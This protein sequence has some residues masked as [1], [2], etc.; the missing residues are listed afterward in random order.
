M[1][2]EQNNS[3]HGKN[4]LQYTESGKF[5]Y[6]AAFPH[7]EGSREAL[8]RVASQ[9]AGCGHWSAVEARKFEQKCTTLKFCIF[10]KPEPKIPSPGPI[11][12]RRASAGGASCAGRASTHGP[13]TQGPAAKRPRP[14]PRS[15][16]T[17]TG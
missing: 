4:E 15:T 10:R 5:D 17:R 3:D 9:A 7:A 1:R 13:R 8:C 6:T 14:R 12:L 2:Q 16:S 11:H